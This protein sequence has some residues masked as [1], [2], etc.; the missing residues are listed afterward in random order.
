MTDN[1][2]NDIDAMVASQLKSARIFRGMTQKQLAQLSGLS[3]KQI[4][5]YEQ[6]HDRIPI[7]KLYIFSCLLDLPIA[8][9]FKSKDVIHNE[10]QEAVSELAT[11][12][13]A[14]N[15]IGD[16][17][18]RKKVISLVKYMS[19]NIPSEEDK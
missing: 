11:L 8:F 4:Q 3:I 5:R 1:N 2:A 14:F 17:N 16:E 13:K 10:H 9:F 12:V 18:M 19:E 6:G 7:N 15:D